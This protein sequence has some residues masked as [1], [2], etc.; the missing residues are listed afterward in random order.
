VW[1]HPDEEP[2]SVGG[3]VAGPNPYDQLLAALGT[4]TSITLWMLFD[5][6]GSP[7]QHVSAWFQHDRID[8][9][10]CA[11]CTA[12]TGTLT[13]IRQ[14]VRLDGPQAAEQPARTDFHRRSLPCIPWRGQRR[15]CR[16]CCATWVWVAR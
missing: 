7:L 13:R 3:V 16:P 1:A 5:W 15:P 8:T 14:D 11:D 4:W 12:G 10:E 2:A 9:K 6:N